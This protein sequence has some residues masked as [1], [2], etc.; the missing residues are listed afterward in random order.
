MTTSQILKSQDFKAVAEVRPDEKK[1]LLLTKVKKAGKMYRIFENSLGQIILDPV[2][3]MPESEVW[4]FKNK[5][6]IASVRK[7]LK[8]AGEGKL[9][10][11]DSYAKHAEDTLG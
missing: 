2:V 9:V 7:G 6:A 8:E 3:T 11:R 5:A 4:L 1:R 10:T